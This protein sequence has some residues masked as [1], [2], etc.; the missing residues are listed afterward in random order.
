MRECFLV[1]VCMRGCVYAC[2][3]E[4]TCVCADLNAILSFYACPLVNVSKYK[5]SLNKF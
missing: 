3:S 5:C 4:S 2:A 1:C